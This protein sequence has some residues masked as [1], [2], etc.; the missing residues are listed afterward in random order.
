[1]LAGVEGSLP[2]DV[3]EGMGAGAAH[4][5][6]AGFG[7]RRREPMAEQGHLIRERHL[8]DCQVVGMNV[9][10][11]EAGHQVRAF[12]IDDTG[13]VAGVAR[14]FEDVVGYFGTQAALDTG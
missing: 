11:P 10:V 14:T 1:M 12:K 8:V 13:A 7:K 3:H 2:G 9:H 6:N 4:P 5:D